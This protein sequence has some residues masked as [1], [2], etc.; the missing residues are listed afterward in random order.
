M[1]CEGGSVFSA[2]CSPLSALRSSFLTRRSSLCLF[3]CLFVFLHR[4]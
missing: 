2:L 3:V 1:R 4:T